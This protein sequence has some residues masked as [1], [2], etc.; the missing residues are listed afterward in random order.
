VRYYRPKPYLKVEPAEIAVDK[1]RI[2]IVP[3]MVRISLVYMPDF[4]EEYSIDV[5]PGLGTAD[6]GIKLQDGWNLT[7]IS[8]ELD[9]QTDENLEALGSILGAVADIVPTAVSGGEKLLSMTANASN[10]PVGFYESVIGRDA[11]GCKRLYG[12]RY[13]GFI[14]FSSCPIEMGGSQ[15]ACCGDP[16]APLYGLNFVDGQMTFDTLENLANRAVRTIATP[17]TNS[18]DSHSSSHLLPSATQHNSPESV[19]TVS[20]SLPLDA[21]ASEQLA[22]QLRTHL[23]NLGF[24]VGAVYVSSSPD[25]LVVQLKSP[26]SSHELPL[27]VATDDWLSMRYPRPVAI[28]IQLLR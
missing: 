6:V 16:Q 2:E 4:A 19:D 7:E 24:D 21:A 3:H 27:K 8:Q 5:R 22:I 11:R 12:F 15:A 26:G 18:A 14:P 10:V 1:T 9:S 28:D 20:P 13:L 23:R 17:A 25:R